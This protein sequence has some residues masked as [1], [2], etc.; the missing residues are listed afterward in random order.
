MMDISGKNGSFGQNF[1]QNL[2]WWHTISQA[3]EIYETE[4]IIVI[5]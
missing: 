4:N 2:S 1:S 3:E 5:Y